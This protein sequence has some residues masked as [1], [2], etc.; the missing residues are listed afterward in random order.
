MIYCVNPYYSSTI[1]FF[2]ELFHI[3]CFI[4]ETRFFYKLEKNILNN[5]FIDCFYLIKERMKK[6]EF[7][8]KII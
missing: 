7:Y 4:L 2:S 6:N 8:E 1:S 5:Y 3:C